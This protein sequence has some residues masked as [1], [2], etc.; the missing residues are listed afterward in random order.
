MRDFAS[1]QIGNQIWM[2]KNWDS[3]FQK[4]WWYENDSIINM[5]Y[6]RLYFYSSAI[7][8]APPGWHLPSLEEWQQLINHFGGDSFAASKMLDGSSG[9]NLTLSGHKSANITTN[10]LFD[11]KEQFGYYWTSTVKGEQ[12]A[13]AIEFRKGVSNV[14]KNYYRKANGFSVRYV[15]D[16]K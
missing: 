9:L 5:K 15:K 11:L 16:K 10:D 12:T 7:A 1:V 13:F 14:V 2:T 8:S 4:S 3:P 6:G